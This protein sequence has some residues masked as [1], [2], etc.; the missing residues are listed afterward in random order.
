LLILRGRYN[1]PA[2]VVWAGVWE[3]N[4][5]GAIKVASKV[6]LFLAEMKRRKVYRVA[7]VYVVVGAGIIGL[8]E[9]ALP[10]N[11]WEGI[12]IP[13]GV[14]ILVGLPIALILAWAYE[15]RPEEPRPPEPSDEES[16]AAPHA[17]AP[18]GIP[19]AEHRKSIVV[20]PFDNMSPDPGDAYLSD[21]L[22]EEI[23]TNLSHLR[24]LRVISRSSAM[25]LKGTQKD[26]RTIGEELDVQYVLEG[27]VRKVADDLRMTAQLI[28][29]GSDEHLWAETYK[30]TMADVFRI[31]EETARSI[32]DALRLSLTPEEEQVLGERDIQDVEAYQLYLMAKQDFWAGTPDGLER[33]RRQL[34]NG[35]ELIGENGALLEGLAEVQFHTYLYGVKT[36]EET[37]GRAEELVSRAVAVDPDSA[38][39]QYLQGRIE[40][41]RHRVTNGIAHFERALTIDP[42]HSNSLG[43]LFHSYSMHAGRPDY[44]APMRE[45]FRAQNPLL[46]LVWWALGVHDWLKGDLEKALSTFRRANELEG[47]GAMSDICIAYILIWLDRTEEARSLITD[48]VRRETPDPF[49]GLAQFLE[50]AMEGKVGSAKEALGETTRNYLWRNPE[51]M[52]LGTSTFALAGL[53]SEALDWLE[54]M[55]DCGWINYPLLSEQDPLLKSIRGEERFK[56]LMTGVKRDWEAFGAQLGSRA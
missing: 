38:R 13:V 8:C 51:Y 46:F 2:E 19:A 42:T 22:T 11:L 53:K 9:A 36:D 17:T 12:Q 49:T 33:A 34:E 3:S 35:L 44:A 41:L 5:T 25:V 47:G 18:T 1:L 20:L 29:A 27:S 6:S 43:M 16:S 14:I 23:T 21:G 15:V 32:V 30:G 10:P 39:S 50:K 26:V 40:L 56:T 7:T 54:H 52:W 55:V 37:L 4:L 45:L 31:Q 28:D 24:S 48:L